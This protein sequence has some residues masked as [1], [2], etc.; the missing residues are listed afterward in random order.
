MKKFANVNNRMLLALFVVLCAWFVLLNGSASAGRAELVDTK[1]A[2][3][4]LTQLRTQPPTEMTTVI[5]TLKERA[6]LSNIHAP[7]RPTRIKKVIE[8]LQ[9]TATTTQSPVQAVLTSPRF[10]GQVD[11][12]EPYWIFN[13][14]V[15]K[16][17]GNVIEEIAV[18]HQVE[19][20][21]INQMYQSPE[22]LAG[23]ASEQNIDLVNAPDLWGMGFTGSGIV[24]GTMDS[25][26]D[27]NHPDLATQFRGGSNSWFDPHGEHPTTPTDLSGHGTQTMGVILGRDSGGTAVGM[28]P[29][30]QWIAVKIFNDAGSATTAAIH[31]GYQW[32]LDPDGDPGTAD[33]PHIVN[34]SWTNGFPGCDLTFQAD[35]QALRAANILP[36]FAAG[37]VGGNPATSTSPG[38]YPEAFAV[39]GT[40]NSD[41]LYVSSSQGPSACG[42]AE[43][44]FPELVA[45]GVSVRST[46]LFGTYAT[47]SG[48]SL[49]APHVAGGLALL[50][51]AFPSLTAD[52]QEAALINGAVDLGAV[53]LDNLFGNGRLDLL[54]SYQWQSTNGGNPTATPLPPTATPVPP[55]STPLPPTA[56]PLPP[57]AT[58]PP[59]PSVQFYLSLNSAGPYMVGAVPDVSNEDILAF[60]GTDFTMI[61]DGSDVGLTDSNVD[62]IHVIDANTFLLSFT[63]PIA[64]GTLGTVDDSDIVQFNATSTG[65]VTAGTFSWY[66]DGSDVALT[67]NGE[68]IDGMVLL[69]DGR[70]LITTQGNA[71]TGGVVGRDEDM[72]A[73]T[74]TTIGE[75][76]NGSWALYFDGTD[77]ALEAN[78]ED[79]DGTAVDSNG[80]LSLSTRGNFDVGTISG[81][82][83][84][85]F[86][87]TL[88]TTGDN[89]TGSYDPLLVFDGNAYGLGGNDINGLSIPS[90]SAPPPTAT[91]L[92]PTTTPL[93]PTATSVPPTAT[94]LPPTA[95][96]L[97]STNTPLPP[98]ATP[99]PPTATP[100]PP[101]ATPL[102]PTNTPLPPTAT[103]LPPTATP[104]PPTNTPLPPTATSLPPTA[105]PLPPTSTPGSSSMHVGDLDGS[106]S[107]AGFRW[108]AVT[109]ITVHDGGETAVSGA[110]IS[111]T[112]TYGSRTKSGSCVTDVNGQCDVTV[113]GIPL[114]LPNTAFVVDDVVGTLPYDALA[115]HDPDTD[116]DGTTIIVLSP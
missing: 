69:D 107:G 70:I 46:D 54:A 89:T 34:N 14:M 103:S 61:F 36:I 50:L 82:D 74:P 100:L 1:I 58:Q 90:Q 16:A 115:N 81:N 96:P 7:D 44:I 51:N 85:L 57:T 45:P 53:G 41:N 93:P 39:G 108:D 72:L 77:V 99:L 12:V 91:P 63:D 104:L 84:D 22:P 38:N 35:L 49:S 30:A 4:L 79:L 60:D 5:V 28:A 112:W 105:T 3:Q 48:T 9:N 31:A 116:S 95:T 76:T 78:S 98:T 71:Y 66:F 24:I 43:E 15:V 40:D 32:L 102:L 87:I 42:E 67:N 11:F 114:F 27:V 33:T 92:P 37:N 59:A 8:A 17:T 25:G 68:D 101:T 10:A 73:F 55:T 65:E 18:M 26:V 2:P 6:N 94:L 113:V 29:N 13:G 75:T 52:Q 62:A 97:P 88:T 110:T 19:S 64:V 109:T 56:T 47:N 83:D 20:V 106:S 80:T 86:N 111:G 21:T 23:A